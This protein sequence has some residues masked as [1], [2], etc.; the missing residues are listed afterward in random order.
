MRASNIKLDDVFGNMIDSVI[1]SEQIQK[2]TDFFS[3]KELNIS[4]KKSLLKN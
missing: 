4:I 3:K 2:L 1:N